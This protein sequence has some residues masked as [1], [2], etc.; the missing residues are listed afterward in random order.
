MTTRARDNKKLLE[1]EASNQQS[2]K[3]KRAQIEK[4]LELEQKL[5][6]MDSVQGLAEQISPSI[7]PYQYRSLDGYEIRLLEI[8]KLV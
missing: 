6:R 8:V 2:K 1:P 3:R 4:P 7:G 5:L